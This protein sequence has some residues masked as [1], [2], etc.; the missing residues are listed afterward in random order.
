MYSKQWMIKGLLRAMYVMCH[1][2]TFH[3]TLPYS[4]LFRDSFQ[5]EKQTE[6]PK[7]VGNSKVRKQDKFRRDWSSLDIRTHASPKE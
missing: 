5:K 3:E 1:S 6:V 2:H 7:D 4:Y